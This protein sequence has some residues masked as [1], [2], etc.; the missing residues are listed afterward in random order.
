MRMIYPKR[1]LLEVLGKWS[2]LVGLIVYLWYFGL[3]K[4]LFIYLPWLIQREVGWV[5]E[6]GL[7]AVL[8]DHGLMWVLAGLSVAGLLLLEFYTHYRHKRR[9]LRIGGQLEGRVVWIK[10]IR[11]G[12]LYD[13]WDAKNC[14]NWLLNKKKDTGSTRVNSEGNLVSSPG[15]WP[16]PWAIPFGE[17]TNKDYVVY[18][19]RRFL[20]IVP[21]KLYVSRDFNLSY[22]FFHYWL[23]NLRM[24]TEPHPEKPGLYVYRL[25]DLSP[26]GVDVDPGLLTKENRKLL[27]RSKILVGKAILSDAETQKKDFDQ[28]SYSVPQLQEDEGVYD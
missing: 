10:G 11:Q 26:S 8:T 7:Q 20:Q 16:D 9:D 23:P 27:G 25:A 5:L 21:S 28:G 13:I 14:I 12:L 4:I 1:R 6:Y 3:F 19:Q 24:V 15:H 17:R 2:L 18:F 22:S